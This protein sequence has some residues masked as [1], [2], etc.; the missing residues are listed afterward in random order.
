M[1]KCIGLILFGLL[2]VAFSAPVYAQ[3]EWKVSGLIDS[4]FVIYK[5]IFYSSQI[6]GGA[7]DTM[8]NPMGDTRSLNKTGQYFNTRGRFKF[9]AVMGKDVTGTMFFEMDSTR[10]GETGTNR[11]NVGKWDADRDA[12]E[13]KNLFLDFGIPY[14]G[15]PIPMTARVGI[16][17]IAVRPEMLVNTDGPGIT[18]GFKLDPVTISPFWAKASHSKDYAAADADV[19]GANL[20]A[21]VSTMTLGAYGMFYDMRTYPLTAVSVTTSD[22]TN[23][24]R[25]YWFGGYA[26]GKLGP[27]NML[28]DFVM[29]KGAVKTYAD[30]AQPDVNYQGWAS[31]L[32]LSLPVE[33]FEIGM[34]GMYASGSD[35]TKTSGTGTP[36]STV[37]NTAA[38]GGASYKVGSYVLPP[39]SNNE[40]SFG[41]QGTGMF[42]SNPLTGR[43][44]AFNTG[45]A[46]SMYR[47]ALGGTYF[48]EAFASMKL[49][50]WYKVTFLGE[51]IGDTTTNGNTLGTA[52]KKGSTQL[53]DDNFIGWE[54]GLFNEIQIYK[55]LSWGT[56][57]SYLIAGDALDIRGTGAPG[58]NIS[59]DNPWFVGSIVKYTW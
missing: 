23:K 31:R 4:N 7:T 25:M 9:D 45:N 44:P 35:L 41:A 56:V 36:G 52:Q 54:L 14:F 43:T 32:K 13:V 59:P 5:N 8:G 24:A 38:G 40:S 51:Y 22:P 47:G 28:A 11:N 49:A 34:Q 18:L 26:D 20:I 15:V 50:P 58:D 27:M 6:T 48:I 10:W 17:P 1:K 2:I 42:Y 33:M 12:V 19:F 3:F 21:K 55:N 37:S 39:A 29:D 53:R 30:G 16:Q 57:F 46:T